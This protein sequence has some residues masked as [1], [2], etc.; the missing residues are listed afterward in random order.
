[1]NRLIQSKVAIIVSHVLREQS[2]QP[3]A[4]TV[5]SNDLVLVNLVDLVT[6]LAKAF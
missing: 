1:M 4:Y 5:L 2:Y 3:Y 6:T